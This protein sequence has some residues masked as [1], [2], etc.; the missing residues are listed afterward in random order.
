MLVLTRREGESVCIGPD[1]RVT[2][3]ALASGKVRIAIE[4]PPELAV[5]R[6][7]VYERIV[8]ANQE[9]AAAAHELDPEL[10]RPTAGQEA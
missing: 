2:V 7:E 10:A 9:A 5:H 4:A 8:R 3:V 6:E 1:V